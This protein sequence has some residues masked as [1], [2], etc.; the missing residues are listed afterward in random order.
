MSEVASSFGVSLVD[1]VPDRM[2]VMCPITV[3]IFLDR[4][5][6]IRWGVRPGQVAKWLGVWME[7]NQVVRT[8]KPAQPWR[9]VAKSWLVRWV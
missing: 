8:G 3:G 5:L 1:L 7:A 4:D 6:L 9:K 2:L